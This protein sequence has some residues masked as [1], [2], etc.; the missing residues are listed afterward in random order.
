MPSRNF[1]ARYALGNTLACNRGMQWGG[2]THVGML[3]PTLNV[4][5]IMGL[6]CHACG[7]EF[8]QQDL[9]EL[10]ASPTEWKSSEFHSFAVCLLLYVIMVIKERKARLQEF[11]QILQTRVIQCQEHIKGKSLHLHTSLYKRA[12]FATCTINRRRRVRLILQETISSGY[13]NILCYCPSNWGQAMV[14]Q[15]EEKP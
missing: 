13:K 14:V 6:L 7:R 11:L 4:L 3:A 10:R 2:I 9:E 12:K 8:E 1:A 5:T 15:Y